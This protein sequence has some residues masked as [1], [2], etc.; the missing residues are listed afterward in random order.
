MK[1]DAALTERDNLIVGSYA[2]AL[3]AWVVDPAQAPSIDAQARAIDRMPS[4]PE[5]TKSLREW[6][7]RYHMARLSM[8]HCSPES[9]ALA[10]RLFNL[11]LSKAQTQKLRLD[12]S[13]V[14]PEIVS[15]VVSSS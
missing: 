9:F 3:D 14:T 2:L 12:E 11:A 1:L 5:K 13:P 4:G 7:E 15:N 6:S 10:A 8:P